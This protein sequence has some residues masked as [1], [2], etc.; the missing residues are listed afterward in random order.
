MGSD[1]QLIVAAGHP[2]ARDLVALVKADG[3]KAVLS[4]VPVCRERSTLD[5]A[6]LRYH[7]DELLAA[8]ILGLYHLGYLLVFLERQQIDD[9]ASAGGLCALGQLVAFEPVHNSE[10]GDEQYMVVGRADIHFLDEIVLTLLNAGN[11]ASAAVL[12]LIGRHGGPL[13]ITRVGVG[14]D[15][16]LNGDEV[17]NIDLAADILDHGAALVAELLLYLLDLADDDVEHSLMICEDIL[18]VGDLGL[19]L[20]QLV[21]YLLGLET[22]QTAEDHI[23]DMVCLDLREAEAGHKSFLALGDV[24]RSLHDRD[25]LVDIVKSYFQTSEN[26]VSLPGLAE[27]ESR[28]SLDDLYLEVDILFET[29]LE[30]EYLRHAVYKRQHDDADGI[31]KLS[32]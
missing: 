31:L 17:F 24:L 9:I 4:D 1:Y 25:D 18:V 14:Y 10:I 26:M 29:L 22:G 16:L 20:S 8:E 15:A 2:Y 21:E 13:D 32:I 12:S 30:G 3:D 28:S 7:Y 5:L 27:I 6:V 11:S 23:C 19:D